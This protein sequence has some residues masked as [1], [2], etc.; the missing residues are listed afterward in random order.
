M[1]HMAYSA[2]ILDVDVQSL[3]NEILSHHHAGFDDA[4]LLGEI[5]LAEVLGYRIR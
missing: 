2:V 5:L 4:A 3:R 1:A